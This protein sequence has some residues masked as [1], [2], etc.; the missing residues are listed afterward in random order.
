MGGCFTI[1]LLINGFYNLLK[2]KRES[3]IL[4]KD[5]VKSIQIKSRCVK[6][7]KDL[8][9]S[10]NFLRGGLN[11]SPRSLSLGSAVAADG[12]TEE[13]LKENTG[14]NKLA[15]SLYSTYATNDVI[16]LIAI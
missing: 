14:E 12:Q 9:K 15:I 11:Y 10:S 6:V 8:N 4:Y 13:C 7:H 5:N 1:T 3:Q 16:T 2:A